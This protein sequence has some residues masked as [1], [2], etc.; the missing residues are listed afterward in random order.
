M[1]KLLELKNI[2]ASYAGAS[3]L[4]NVSIAIEKNEILGL[5]GESG[6]GKSTTAKVVTGLLKPDSGSVIFNA[7]ELT[8]KRDKDICRRIPVSYTHL[9]QSALSKRIKALED[10]LGVQ[11]LKRSRGGD[12]SYN[13][14]RNCT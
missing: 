10:A 9:T 6:S 3:V 14:R 5:V 8:G 1:S 13:K 12:E 4:E 2:Y 7:K 11:L